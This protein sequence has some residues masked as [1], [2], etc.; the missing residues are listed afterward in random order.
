MY[1]KTHRKKHISTHSRVCAQ[2][3]EADALRARIAE[4]E[5]Q[6]KDAMGATEKKSAQLERLREHLIEMEN[7]H[8]ADAVAREEV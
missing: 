5:Q 3:A 2:S 1:P 7:T 4:L 8:T 6:V